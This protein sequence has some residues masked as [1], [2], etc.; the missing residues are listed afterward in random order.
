MAARI[1]TPFVSG[2]PTSLDITGHTK[3]VTLIGKPAFHS[4]SPETH[5]LAWRKVGIDAIFLSFEIDLDGLDAAMQGFRNIDGWIGLT[6][7]MPLKQAIVK[8]MDRLNDIARLSNAVNIVRK[9]EDGSLSGFNS[10]GPGFMNNLAKSGF[11]APN[12]RMVLLGPGGAGRAIM[13]QAALD[14]V[15]EIDVFARKGG[16]SF[17]EASKVAEA[18]MQ[19]SDCKIRMFPFE[20]KDQMKRS[21]DSADVLVNAS[22]VGMGVGNTELP[23]DPAL[24]KQGMFVADVVNTPRKTQLLKD[25]EAR[26][27]V[28]VDGLGML[29][30]QAVVADLIRFGIE[31]P[32][33]EVRAELD[34]SSG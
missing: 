11:V 6:V 8:H 16:T 24:I 1:E 31:I 3:L 32:I 18:L 14:G 5:T 10:D 30:Q 15:A 27:C 17:K 28:V 13:V 33:E 22:N 12:S 34:A 20:D 2:S 29:D 4:K 26:G 19:E 7:T 9:E 21:I 23:I 25:A